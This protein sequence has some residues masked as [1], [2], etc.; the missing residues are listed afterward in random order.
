MFNEYVPDS[1]DEHPEEKGELADI[2][3]KMVMKC[4]WVARAARTDLARA[5]GRL[6]TKVSKLGKREDKKLHRMMCYTHHTG[7]HRKIG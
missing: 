3:L 1:D 2:A 4:M 6:A 5:I 7:G